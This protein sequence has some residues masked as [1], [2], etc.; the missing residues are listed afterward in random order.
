MTGAAMSD[1]TGQDEESETMLFTTSEGDVILSVEWDREVLK[2]EFEKLIGGLYTPHPGKPVP[3]DEKK[4][5]IEHAFDYTVRHLEQVF[6]AALKRVRS[7]AVDSSARAVGRTRGGRLTTHKSLLSS[8]D[9]Q[10]KE[11]LGFKQR[12]QKSKWNKDELARAVMEAC[13]T[14]PPKDRTYERV[15]SV[16]KE[17]HP[18]KAPKSAAAL[19]KLIPRHGLVWKALK[20]DSITDTSLSH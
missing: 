11:R 18:D 14:L 20:G 5:R 2:K 15:C 6:R 16:L 13:D 9:K 19:K 7:E 1:E 8:E 17:R 3:A 12:G 10:A 4:Q